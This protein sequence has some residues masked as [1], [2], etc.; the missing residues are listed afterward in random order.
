[1]R[2][3]KF[4]VGDEVYLNPDGWAVAHESRRSNPLNTR[5]EVT[6]VS[7]SFACVK[8]DNGE[9]NL[10]YLDKSD[11]WTVDEWRDSQVPYFTRLKKAL[12]EFLR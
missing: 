5:G 7:S 6:R 11:F 8:W 4:K 12:M 2:N 10:Y 3:N 1:M 9:S